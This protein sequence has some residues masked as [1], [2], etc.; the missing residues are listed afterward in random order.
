[1]KK[2]F[3]L[4]ATLGLAGSLA[5]CG[6]QQSSSQSSSS[7]AQTTNVKKQSSSKKAQSSSKSTK[8]SKSSQK[9]SSSSTASSSASSQATSSSTSATTSSQSSTATSASA[10]ATRPAQLSDNQIAVLVYRAAGYSNLNG[11]MKGSAPQGR[12]AIGAGTADSTVYYTF[13]GNSVTIYTLQ[14]DPTKSTAEQGFNT[15]YTTI[16][17]LISKYYSTNGQQQTVNQ[18]ANAVQTY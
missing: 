18:A 6:N 5:A 16:N 1:M 8:S 4:L 14:A 10:S 13:S 9:K 12:T 7:S 2:A 3:L 17:Q 11:L 15:S